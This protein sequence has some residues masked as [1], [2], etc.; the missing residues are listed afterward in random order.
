[1][2]IRK[3]NGPFRIDNRKST[4][5]YGYYYDSI[6]ELPFAETKK[7]HVRVYLPEDYDFDN[8]KQ[9]YPVIYFSDGQNLV[10]R[11][12]SAYGDWELSKT[13]HRLY[14]EGYGTC[15]L[16]GIDCPKN[17]E[18]RALELNP[19]YMINKRFIEGHFG[20]K[21]PY[22]QKYVNYVADELKPLID[23]LFYT[24]PDRDFT[25]SGGSSMGGAYSF[26]AYL[27]RRDVFGFNLVFSPAFFLYKRND[28]I[29]ILDKYSI[30][31]NDGRIF[32]Y[33][34]GVDFERMFLK[35]V[36]NTYEYLLKRKFDS[37]HLALIVDDQQI[38]HEA[39]WA[40]YSYDALKYW[41]TK[42]KE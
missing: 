7:R 10:N 33:V 13:M 17:P 6:F 12:L 8:P 32:L 40:K 42:L 34:G 29:K 15:I 38:H 22:G 30:E 4:M 20:T 28:W 14:K 35:P 5:K 25:G 18:E 21:M 23:E 3:Q 31:G 24:I 2:N 16:V 37:D 26:Y 41:F 27:S 36:L 1:M 19:P 11:Y 39:A 9:R